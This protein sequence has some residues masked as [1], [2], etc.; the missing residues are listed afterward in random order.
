MPKSEAQIPQSKAFA[1]A[2]QMAAEMLGKHAILNI[3]IKEIR[4]YTSLNLVRHLCIRGGHCW[5][6]VFNLLGCSAVTFFA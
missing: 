5:V 4:S 2:A 6:R 3:I 1:R